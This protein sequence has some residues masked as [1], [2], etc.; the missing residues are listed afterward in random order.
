MF[1]KV[2]TTLFLIAVCIGLVFFEFYNSKMKNQEEPITPFLL[3][4][5]CGI[6]STLIW[7]L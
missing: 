7:T 1:Y 4:G 2:C 5:F 3:G 6:I